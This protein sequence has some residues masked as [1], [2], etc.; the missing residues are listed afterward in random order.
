MDTKK[1]V[2]R[3][4]NDTHTHAHIQS[5][6]SVCAH[7]SMYVCVYTHKHV[8]VYI[9]TN[10]HAFL[11]LLYQLHRNCTLRW[12]WCIY[13]YGYLHA[14][15]VVP[16]PYMHRHTCILAAFASAATAQFIPNIPANIH[17][18]THYLYVKTSVAS[19]WHIRDMF[20]Y[21]HT[22]T[23]LYHLKLAYPW[24]ACIHMYTHTYCT[25]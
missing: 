15:E 8:C 7:T 24:Y 21:T 4:T 5:C 9:H 11:Q 18:W 16:H 2:H 3:H 19:T 17:V 25:S 13:M 10:I 12:Y 1:Y 23:Y 22:Y 14:F 20:M 6:T